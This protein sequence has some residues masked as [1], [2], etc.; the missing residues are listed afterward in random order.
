MLTG[1]NYHIFVPISEY[2]IYII[3]F[4]SL[5]QAL[6]N[7]LINF[8]SFCLINSLIFLIVSYSWVWNYNKLCNN[9]VINF[10]LILIEY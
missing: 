10:K 2:V 3:L 4:F 5:S 9:Y 6:F 7:F 8:I 1:M